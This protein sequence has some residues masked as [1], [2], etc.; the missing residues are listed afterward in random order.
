M[1]RQGTNPQGE[2]LMKTACRHW[3]EG[4][5]DPKGVLTSTQKSGRDSLLKAEMPTKNQ[6]SWRLTDLERLKK[7]FTLPLAQKIDKEDRANSHS[8]ASTPNNGLRIVLEPNKN[9]LES[10]TLPSGICPLTPQEIQNSLKRLAKQHDWTLAINYAA[11]EKILALKIKGQNLPA[12]ELVLPAEQDKF[13]PTRVILEIEENSTLQLLQIVLGSGI[14]AHSH[15]IQVQIGKGAELNHGFVALGGGQASCLAHISIEQESF[16]QYCLT[17]IQHG[18]SLSRLEPRIIQL[19]KQG[20]TTLKGL[21]ISTGNEQLSTHSL[22]HFDGPEGSLKQLQKAAA[23][24][25]SHSIFN[26][27]VEV[28]QVAQKTNAEQLSRNLLLSRN[29]R[30]DAKPEL[31]IVADDVK[32]THGATVSQLQEEELFYLQSRGIS[33]NQASYLLLKGYCKEI[34]DSLPVEASRWQILNKILEN[35]N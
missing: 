15:L 31:A 4:L 7:L 19:D 21:Q 25:N 10:I 26:G 12:L 35:I 29:A 34:V 18:W 9:P 27:I 33:S 1:V 22:V 20:I 16:S 6:E 11:T 3:L 32:C 14:S 28:P 5:P 30:I 13:N 17:S 2:Q 23:N 24:Q 8:W